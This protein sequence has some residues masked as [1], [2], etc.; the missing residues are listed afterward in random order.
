[1]PIKLTWPNVFAIAGL[2]AAVVSTIIGGTA[3]IVEWR[4]VAVQNQLRDRM[5]LY[6]R[7]AEAMDERISRL[8]ARAYK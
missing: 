2:V 8:E 1:M 3:I 7:E 4:L 5:T 6:T